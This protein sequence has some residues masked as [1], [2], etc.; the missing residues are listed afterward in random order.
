[1][2]K[3]NSIASLAALYAVFFFTSGLGVVNPAIQGIAEAFPDIPLNTIMQI[4]TLP[5]LFLIPATIIAG[6]VAGNKVKFKTLIKI[7]LILYAI[8]GVVPA[9]VSD[10]TAILVSRAV[11]G[12]GVGILFSLSNA[13]V[14][15]LF[16]G[17]QRG[18]IMGG[19][20]VAANL[21]GIVLQMLGG[22]LVAMSWKYTFYAHALGF[23]ALL[24]VFIGFP[25]PETIEEETTKEKVKLPGAVFV[26]ATLAGI[27]FLLVFPLL[28]SLSTI[29]TIRD[30]G[31][32]TAAGL[33]LSLFTV[34]GMISSVFF[35]KLY[36]TL[37][38]FTFTFNIIVTVLG[39]L[40]VYFA[41]SIIVVYIGMTIVGMGYMLVVPTLMM[42]TGKI[43][44]PKG[45]PLAS[46]FI[47]GFMNVGSFLSTYYIT[48]VGKV[49][50]NTD[51]SYPILVSIV[52]FVIIAVIYTIVRFKGKNS[53][54][55]QK[56]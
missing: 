51:V 26:F 28:V 44:S 34:G 50:G 46:G 41:N 52:M 22:I 48:L 19:G 39:M 23:I 11:V 33:G 24:L 40:V 42:E 8:A 3:K 15:R 29:I 7:G 14:I 20:S 53:E 17:Q 32:G 12:V 21:G 55:V 18:N 47:I 10:F 56:G 27:G 49:S 43:T 30:M 31:S 54:I 2:E 36:K 16:D 25:E 4:S 37:N 35:G 9:F 6:A 13:S 45:I 1:M 5:S 38:R